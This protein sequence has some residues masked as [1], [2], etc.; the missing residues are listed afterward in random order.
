MIV[1]AEIIWRKKHR[2]NYKAAC[3]QLVEHRGPTFLSH[4]VFLK[5]TL[6]QQYLK[7]L[8]IKP[9]FEVNKKGTTQKNHKFGEK[10]L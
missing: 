5:K 8:S 2:I 3:W 9:K 6:G 1:F 10:N 4:Y 7:I